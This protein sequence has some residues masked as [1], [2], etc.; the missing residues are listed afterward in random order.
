MTEARVAKPQRRRYP[1]RLLAAALA[2]VLLLGVAGGLLLW[3]R[4]A[5]TVAVVNGE[6]I[7][8]ARL[9]EAMYARVG[10]EALDDIIGAMLVAQAA[11]QAGVTVSEAD[12][13]RYMED[14]EAR[15]GGREAFDAAL[16]YY[17][18]TRAAV[19]RDVRSHLLAEAVVL[20]DVQITEAEMREFFE[21]NRQAFG[22]PEKVK[23]SHILLE[24]E[25]EAK[26]LLA[27]LRAGEDFAALAAEFSA[28]P[29]SAT[30]GGD[31]GFFSR[32]DMIPEFAEAAFALEVGQMSGVV[33]SFFGYHLIRVTGREPAVEPEYEAVRDQVL[34]AVR[35]ARAEELVSEW[36]W[37]LRLR[38]HIEYRRPG[39]R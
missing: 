33:P 38:A 24:T 25:E 1:V 20:K 12:L 17:G 6:R 10:E 22:T 28:D 19:E 3:W 39:G 9:F 31:L 5:D 35:Q 15:F 37:M 36:M 11:R 29:A 30:Q 18:V 23:A 16:V 21:Q 34:T 13:Q 32:E 7:T 2:A 14:L 4:N 26:A 27:R 8:R